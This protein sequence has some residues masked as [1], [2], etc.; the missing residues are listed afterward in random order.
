MK[1]YIRQWIIAILCLLGSCTTVR[2]MAYDPLFILAMAIAEN[3][4]QPE[5]RTGTYRA[6]EV[7]AAF[8][9]LAAEQRKAI[10]AL[11]DWAYTYSFIFF[12][13]IEG[14]EYIPLA[15]D[16]DKSMSLQEI[17]MRI[18]TWETWETIIDEKFE[19]ADAQIK[20]QLIEFLKPLFEKIVGD[21]P[22][23]HATRSKIKEQIA[24]EN[25]EEDIF[26]DG[27]AF[28][29]V[30]DQFVAAAGKILVSSNCII[31]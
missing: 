19:G 23:N 17:F 22:T 4:E 5:I 7:F 24:I 27:F 1:N 29:R 18:G 26:S 30:I 11:E 8:K 12:G 2:G 14:F 6:R 9:E 10:R 21:F 25:L 15:R 3:N 20:S 28:M 31:L 13:P 16:S